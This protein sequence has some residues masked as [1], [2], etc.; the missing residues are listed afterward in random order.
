MIDEKEIEELLGY[1]LECICCSKKFYDFECTLL[2]YGS[3]WDQ[4]AICDECLV[5]IC[6]PQIEKIKKETK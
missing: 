3:K 4:E 5:R 2:P 6:D 1:K